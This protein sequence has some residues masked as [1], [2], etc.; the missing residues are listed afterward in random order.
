MLINVIQSGSK[1]NCTILTDKN[2]NQ[3]ILDCGIRYENISKNIKDFCKL[4]GLFITHEH[5]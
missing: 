5:T 2:D 1:G 4:D 3:L